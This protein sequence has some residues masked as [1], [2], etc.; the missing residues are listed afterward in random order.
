MGR[1]PN[2]NSY[3]VVQHD[4][5]VPVSETVSIKIILSLS[6]KQKTLIDLFQEAKAI[7][8]LESHLNRAVES[9]LQSLSVCID[10]LRERTNSPVSQPTPKRKCSD[11]VEVAD[12]VIE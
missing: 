12:A 7:H 11:K 3:V 9:Y 6:T 8:S 5:A 2:S 1:K 4:D 10:R